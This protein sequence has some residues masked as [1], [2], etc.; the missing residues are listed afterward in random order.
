MLKI[1]VATI[2]EFVILLITLGAVGR[3]TAEAY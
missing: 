1:T 3:D 2:G